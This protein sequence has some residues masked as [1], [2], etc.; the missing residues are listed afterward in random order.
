MSQELLKSAKEFLEGK[1]L[2]ANFVDQY[3]DAWKQEGDS[4]LLLNDDP[5][6]SEKLST[7]FCLADLYNPDED[8]EQYEHD[9]A[10]LR[11]EI[12]K[13]IEGTWKAPE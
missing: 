7:I 3:I 6:L 4:G 5:I 8:R 12:E 13:V 9:E 2:V 1:T 10:R 11:L